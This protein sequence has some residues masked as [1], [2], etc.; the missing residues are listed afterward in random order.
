MDE[1]LSA[2]TKNFQSIMTESKKLKIPQYQ[3]DYSWDE[4]QWDELFSDILKGKSN[5][6][7]HY[8]GALVF[9]NSLLLEDV[10]SGTD[11]TCS[12][13]IIKVL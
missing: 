3:R 2:E 5:R 7:K 10:F 8:M 12:K 1:L 6:S 4:E 13:F 11:V 9:I